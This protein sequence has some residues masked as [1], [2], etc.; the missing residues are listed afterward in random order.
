M[1]EIPEQ[2]NNLR[3]IKTKGKIPC[4]EGWQIDKNYKINDNQFIEYL[5]E[6]DTYGVLC[7]FNNL[8][9]IDMDD[10]NVQETILKQNLLPETFTVKT[11]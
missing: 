10:E 4:E 8:I 9:V 11:A 2:L 7:G 3:F 6:N 5:K 1:I